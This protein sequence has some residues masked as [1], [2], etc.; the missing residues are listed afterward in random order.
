MLIKV[1][2][3]HHLSSKENMR[4]IVNKKVHISSIN[5]NKGSS[6]KSYM[7]E[8]FLKVNLAMIKIFIVL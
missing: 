3:Y 1:F 4:V 7:R 5:K 2:I 6:N 8:I